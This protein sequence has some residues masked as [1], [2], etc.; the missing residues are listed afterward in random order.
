MDGHVAFEFPDRGA[1]P[2]RTHNL[3]PV[4]TSVRRH[5][6]NRFRPALEPC[7]DRSVPATI[8]GVAFYDLNSNGAQDTGEGFAAGV[9]AALSGSGVSANTTTDANGYYEF[10]GLESGS[11]DVSFTPPPGYAVGTPSGGSTTVAIQNANDTIGVG[12]GLIEAGNGSGS[13]VPPNAPPTFVADSSALGLIT[14]NQ[15]FYF[16]KLADDSN[17]DVLTY[18]APN[19]PAGLSIDA[20]SGIISGIPTNLPPDRADHY[21]HGVGERRPGRH[22]A[23]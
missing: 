5:D 23:G 15:P 9:G 20:T 17:D 12:V 7:E 13:G 18:S 14:P 4:I 2:S 3:T 22:R 21:L 8:N 16:H 10:T 11:Y 19:L 1:P 6:A